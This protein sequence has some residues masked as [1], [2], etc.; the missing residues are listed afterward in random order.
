MVLRLNFLT[1][2]LFLK[3]GVAVHAESEAELARFFSGVP[4]PV[5][6]R[7]YIITTPDP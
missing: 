1:P 3:G 4:S 5:P 6:Y 7:R 2:R